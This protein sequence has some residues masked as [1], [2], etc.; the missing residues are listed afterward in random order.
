[1]CTKLFWSVIYCANP[2]PEPDTHSGSL[3]CRGLGIWYPRIIWEYNLAI[4]IAIWPLTHSCTC[5]MV[6]S[7]FSSINQLKFA[8]TT[9]A[10][11][12]RMSSTERTN[13]GK[14]F[15]CLWKCLP[16]L[17][18]FYFPHRARSVP[19]G[20]FLWETQYGSPSLT[21]MMVSI[22]IYHKTRVRTSLLVSK[23]HL[24]ILF[25]LYLSFFFFFGYIFSLYIFLI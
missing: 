24:H 5:E 7:I 16:C 12:P 10:P 15:H 18:L 23:H 3:S 13:R 11:F 14:R 8:S 1:M 25:K 4:V 17:S 20:S 21:S 19:I 2:R 6:S 22:Y 9:R